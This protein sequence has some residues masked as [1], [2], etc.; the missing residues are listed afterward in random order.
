M[1]HRYYVAAD[2]GGTKLLA[3]LYDGE[4]NVLRS[5]KTHGTNGLFRP[6]EVMLA[7]AEVLAAQLIP[8]EVK[9]I[10]AVDFS[11]VGD[12]SLF[13]DAIRRRASVGLTRSHGEGH[14]ALAS[15]G[16]R[17]GIAAQAGTGSDAFLI[18]PDKNLGVGGWS[19]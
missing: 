8:P 3:V 2:G 18:Q 1:E 15:A 11:I 17:Y 14:V 7:E 5:G 10:A 9:E 4:G 13:L 6:R 16:V 19:I 12:S